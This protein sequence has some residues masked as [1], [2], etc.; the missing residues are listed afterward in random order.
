MKRLLIA[1]LLVAGSVLLVAATRP[2]VAGETIVFGS[3]SADPSIVNGINAYG[4]YYN[5]IEG[6]LHCND[7]GQWA[8]LIS[9]ADWA[10]SANTAQATGTGIIQKITVTNAGTYRSANFATDVT[11]IG[12][13]NFVLKL[14]SDG[15]TCAGGNTFTT[16]T[17][18]CTAAADTNTTCTA[19][20]ATTYA[21]GATLTLSISTACATTNQVGSFLADLTT[22]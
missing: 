1:S 14:C 13:G 9:S 18:S 16:C 5:T 8:P 19:G 15:A 10:L 22:P 3:D 21:A 20:S 12:G 6:R 11:G 4:C 17:V 2:R 7:G